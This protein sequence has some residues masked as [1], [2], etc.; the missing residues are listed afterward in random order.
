MLMIARYAR[1]IVVASVAG[2][3]AYA[4]TNKLAAPATKAAVGPFDVTIVKRAEALLP[5]PESWDRMDTGTCPRTKTTYTVRCALNRA[6]IEA[7]GLS[8]ARGPVAAS[9]TQSPPPTAAPI[10][11]AMD[12]SADHPGGSC[13]TLWDELP[14]FFLSRAKTVTTGAWR[15]DAQPTEVWAGTMADAEA[16]VNYES[17][18]GVE[19]VSRRKAAD[20]LIDFNNDSATTFDDVQAYFRAL[21]ARVLQKGAADLD[22]ST[23][24]LEIEIY[25]GGTG[26]IRTYNGWFAVSGFSVQGSTMRFQVDTSRE[27]APNAV[28]RE[29]L[30]RAAAI[31]SS[32]SVWNR[33]DNRKCPPTAT[34]WSIYCAVERAQIDVAGGFD[35]RRPAG[36]LVRVIVDERTK[37]ATTIIG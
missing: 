23:D 29:I 25:S 13:G 7:A 36:E 15:K 37:A 18:H 14:L 17:R 1:V 6:K 26:V 10:D 9:S 24:R 33:A 5:S 27:I 35:H 21:E 28:D 3:G 4:Q 32:D 19:I 2:S 12:V 22:D 30:V 34:T 8:W 11:C 16:P 20:Q 31:I